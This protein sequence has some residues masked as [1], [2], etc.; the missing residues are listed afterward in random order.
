MDQPSFYGTK[1]Q[2]F[3]VS[4]N[5]NQVRLATGNAQNRFDPPQEESIHLGNVF[6]SL[7]DI[8][9]LL[10]LLMVSEDD[11]DLANHIPDFCNWRRVKS[12]A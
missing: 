7:A 2:S 4:V 11:R 3:C 6:Y 12:K 5:K 8:P 9:K 1:G 10:N